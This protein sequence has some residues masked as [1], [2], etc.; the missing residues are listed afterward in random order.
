MRI[1]GI[2]QWVSIRGEDLNNPVVLELHGGPGTTNLVFL[3]RTRD[4]ERHFTMVRWDMRGSGETFALGG[5]DGQGE[6]SLD[7]I[8]RDALELVAHLRGRLGVGKVLLLA[9]SFSTN[10]GLR[11][12]RNHP[13]LFSAY[14][15]TDQNIYAG[16]REGVDR[17]G[18]SGAELAEHS[19][20][21]LMSDRLS[22]NTMK[23]VVLG[24]RWFS[25]LHTLRGLRG[26]MDAMK[27]SEPLLAQAVS[28]D[29]WAEGTAFEIPVFF[30]QG[31]ADV[32]TPPES[33]R[34]FHADVTAPVT[35]F[36]LIG[37][38]SHFAAF[39]HPDRFLELLLTRVRPV[40]T[41][42]PARA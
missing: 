9:N 32:L 21:T 20:R 1:G 28:I 24:S 11:L 26:Y 33:V 18:W 13:E 38:A 19:K 8:Y 6:L 14:V 34:R 40:V 35:D 29:E 15:G 31:D 27:F 2:D 41:A 36:A 30:F 37:E 5:P 22:A 7:R 42:Q 17:R 23:T 25:P 39:R 10:V 3:P 16:G 4:W 12:A